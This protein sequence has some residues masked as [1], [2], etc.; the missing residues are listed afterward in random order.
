MILYVNCI[1]IGKKRCKTI[2]RIILYP[3]KEHLRAL[4]PLC[5]RKCRKDKPESG[6]AG[7]S[8]R[9]EGAGGKKQVGMCLRIEG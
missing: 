3:E 7:C 9:Q 6:E 4:V 5:R 2:N 1:S 8:R